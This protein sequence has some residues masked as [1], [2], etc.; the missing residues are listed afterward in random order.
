MNKTKIDCHDGTKTQYQKE[1]F[2]GMTILQ[3]DLD[4]LKKAL[5]TY[6]KNK[7]VTEDL[8][9]IIESEEKAQK[10]WDDD[11][12]K[13]EELKTIGMFIGLAFRRKVKIKAQVEKVSK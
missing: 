13:T 10:N 5:Q 3:S 11:D 4:V 8:L 1:Y 7:E 6:P 2:I 9:R 12:P